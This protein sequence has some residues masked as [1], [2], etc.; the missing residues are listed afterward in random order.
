MKMDQYKDKIN[1]A[2]LRMN[3]DFTNSNL[4][5]LRIVIDK[6]LWKQL[7]EEAKVPTVSL[8][9]IVEEQPLILPFKC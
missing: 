1:K 7:K 3:I 5:A 8:K 2:V 9:G 4:L 6:Y